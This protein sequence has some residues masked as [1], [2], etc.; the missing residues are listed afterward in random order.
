MLPWTLITRLHLLVAGRV[1][2]VVLWG[3]F[4]ARSSFACWPQGPRVIS[5]QQKKNIYDTVYNEMASLDPCPLAWVSQES[6]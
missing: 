6:E 5:E 4:E 1:G 2:T 3:G